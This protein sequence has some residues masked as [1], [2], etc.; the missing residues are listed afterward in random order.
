[1][2]LNIYEKKEIIKTYT[3]EAYDLPFGIVEDVAEAIDLDSLKT[4]SD[5]EIIKMVGNLLFKSMGTVKTLLKDIFDGITDE[6]IRKTTIPEI[7]KCL[8][9]IVTYTIGQLNLGTKG[10]N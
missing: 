1:M 8:V 6:E 3:A 2:K 5:V 9:D 4:G 7:A 10:K